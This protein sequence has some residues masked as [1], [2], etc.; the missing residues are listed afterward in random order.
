MVCL[1][2]PLSCYYLRNL[3]STP[4][5]LLIEVTAHPNKCFSSCCYNSDLESS[6]SIY[7]SPSLPAVHA[8]FPTSLDD[9]PESRID[10]SWKINPHY[11]RSLN[12]QSLW[13]KPC[14]RSWLA[15]CGLHIWNSGFRLEG[16]GHY[17]SNLLKS[18][19]A[20]NVR[21]YIT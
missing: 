14:V 1:I 13:Y 8:I 11:R 5:P 9:A 3:I 21:V 20:T 17:V 15:N 18:S 12:F 4:L 6:L 10:N 2:P 7:Y 19:I 16:L